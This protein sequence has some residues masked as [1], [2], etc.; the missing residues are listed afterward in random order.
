MND[1][2]AEDNKLA[3]FRGAFFIAASS[4]ALA[5]V[6]TVATSGDFLPEHAAAKN[7]QSN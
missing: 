7:G 3:P 1:S 4:A 5:S 2:F 6:Q